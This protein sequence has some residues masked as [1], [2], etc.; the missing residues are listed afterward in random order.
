MKRMIGLCLISIFTCAIYS[1]S[2]ENATEKTPQKDSPIKKVSSELESG[3]WQSLF[4]GETLNGWR[5]LTEYS[6]DDGKWEVIDGEITGDQYP[7]GKGGLLV[8]EEKYSNYEV[9][10]EVKADYPIDSGL[11]LRVQPD[12]L[13]YQV[14]ID[15]RPDGEVGAVYCP[16]GGGF[17][18]HNPEAVNLWKKEKYNTV[19]ARIEGQ[20]PRIQVWINSTQVADYTDTMVDGKYRVPET[21]FF[22]I[23]VH[24]GE[25]WGKGKKVHF[26]KIMIKEL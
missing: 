12:V 26:R 19:K 7:D 14:T 18:K 8:R 1:C 11:F 4:D 3:K 6:G 21:G 15:Y 13:S 16:G 22:G 17:L 20:P 25:S 10:A 9:L 5:K 2:S 24:P 23:Q